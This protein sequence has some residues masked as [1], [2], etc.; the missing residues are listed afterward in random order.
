MCIYTYIYGSVLSVVS[1]IYW[2]SQN[3]FP[4]IRGDYCIQY[5][6]ITDLIIEAQIVS[7]IQFLTFR[8]LK[9]AR[10]KEVLYTLKRTRYK[11]QRSYP[12]YKYAPSTR[13]YIQPQLQPGSAS[14]YQ[15]DPSTMLHNPSENPLISVWALNLEPFSSFFLL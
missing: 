8:R 5:V 2:G 7:K 9:K 13:N 11:L 15:L 12:A 14:S 1:D 6:P 3:V 4:P 10:G